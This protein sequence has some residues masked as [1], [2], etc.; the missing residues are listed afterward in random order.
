MQDGAYFH[1]TDQIKYLGL[2]IRSKLRDELDITNRT[3][4]G[5]STMGQLK[6]LFTSRDAPLDLKLH[7]YHAIPM[8]ADLWDAKHRLFSTPMPTDLMYSTIA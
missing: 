2:W 5:Y 7:M 4:S 1:N 3:V 8:N 6:Q